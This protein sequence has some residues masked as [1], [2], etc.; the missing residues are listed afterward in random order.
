MTTWPVIG[1]VG[2]V[3]AGLLGGFLWWGMPNQQRDA[4]LRDA[5]GSVERLERQVD[6]GQARIKAIEKE[7]EAERQ[8]RAQ[9]EMALSQG[10]K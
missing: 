1:I 3:V 9:L 8:R 5:R 6:E 7:L 4:D 10:K 2:A